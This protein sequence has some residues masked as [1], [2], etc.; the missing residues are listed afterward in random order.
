MKLQADMEKIS[1]VYLVR[2]RVAR[3]KGLGVYSLIRFIKEGSQQDSPTRWTVPLNW[4]L[5]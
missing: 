4:K 2:S 1:I 5:K 3:M